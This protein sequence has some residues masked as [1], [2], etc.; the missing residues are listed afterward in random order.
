MG[1]N[2]SHGISRFLSHWCL[3]SVRYMKRKSFIYYVFIVKETSNLAL[4]IN[5]II[6]KM[7]SCSATTTASATYAGTCEKNNV[8][9]PLLLPIIINAWCGGYWTIWYHR[10]FLLAQEHQDNWLVRLSYHK[11]WSSCKMKIRKLFLDHPFGRVLCFKWPCLRND[12]MNIYVSLFRGSSF[13]FLYLANDE[14][15][16]HG[17]QATKQTNCYFD[18]NLLFRIMLR[19]RLPTTYTMRA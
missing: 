8:S 7:P 6:Y 4:S 5:I 14:L 2:Q 9:P 11:H 19:S 16:H 3:P 10:G 12:W 13:I 18:H 17:G 1:S 15:T